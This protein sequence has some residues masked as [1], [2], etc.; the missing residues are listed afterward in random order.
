M[1]AV[2]AI[3]VLLEL[4]KAGW[5]LILAIRARKAPKKEKERP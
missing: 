3:K 4:T 5:E 2:E 1:D